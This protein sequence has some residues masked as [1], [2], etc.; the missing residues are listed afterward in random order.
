[1]DDKQRLNLQEMVNASDAENNTSK[2]RN[3]K[4]SKLIQ[5][6]VEQLLN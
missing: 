4:H 2:I 1:M 6:D 5:S 3:L